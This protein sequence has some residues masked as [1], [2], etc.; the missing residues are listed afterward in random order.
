MPYLTVSIRPLGTADLRV[1]KVSGRHQ[2]SEDG[3]HLIDGVAFGRPFLRKAHRPPLRI[4]ARKRIQ[5]IE[6]GPSSAEQV[7]PE[8]GVVASSDDTAEAGPPRKRLKATEEGARPRRSSLSKVGSDELATLSRSSSHSKVVRFGSETSEE[9]S[10][11]DA[12]FVP[13]EATLSE[14]SSK[15]NSTDSDST[16]STTTTPESSLVIHDSE[17]KAVAPGTGLSKTQKRNERRKNSK[18][19]QSLVSAGVLPAGS[20]HED[21]HNY[22]HNRP[23]DDDEC[24]QDELQAQNEETHVPETTGDELVTETT[25]P[26]RPMLDVASS[27]RLVF[28]S[29]GLRTPRNKQEEA[30]L[31]AKLANNIRSIPSEKEKWRENIDLRAVECCVDGVD[32][33]EPPFPFHQ[34][35]DPQQDYYRAMGQSL[36]AESKKRKR[37][38]PEADEYLEPAPVEDDLP[39]L[40]EDINTLPEFTMAEC[41]VGAVVAFKNIEM[42]AATSWQPR[43][44]EFRTAQIMEVDGDQSVVMQWANRDQP[45]TGHL[46]DEETGERIYE[47]FE[48]PGFDEDQSKVHLQIPN[49]IEAKLLRPA[50]PPDEAPQE[51]PREQIAEPEI[52]KTK[53]R[54]SK[55]SKKAANKVNGDISQQS[56]D[57]ANLANETGGHAKSR[58]GHK[59]ENAVDQQPDAGPQADHLPQGDSSHGHSPP[60][61]IAAAKPHRSKKRGKA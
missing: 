54:K 38:F 49:L 36:H 45:D 60:L 56:R 34:R 50:A 11:A 1:R 15:A 31:Q 39:A 27:K 37:Q 20:T 61:P 42:S 29:L 58:K 59:K 51:S 22:R 26:R 48:M 25:A 2:I 4:P 21:L 6:A 30:E 35:W 28:G 12:D 53:P 52:S 43:M 19:L 7:D 40:P 33:A 41:K 18:A 47:K 13:S 14:K 46:Y 44:S 32:Y 55:K 17:S 9:D 23:Q 3:K 57:V 8:A 16:S 5:L 10:E 24:A